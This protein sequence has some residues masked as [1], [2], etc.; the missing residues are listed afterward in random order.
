[1]II[2]LKQAVGRGVRTVND[3]CVVCIL[4]ER[5]ATSKYKSNIFRSFKYK[6]TATRDLDEVERFTRNYISKG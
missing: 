2:T 1:M 6:K 5:I 4:D 3:K